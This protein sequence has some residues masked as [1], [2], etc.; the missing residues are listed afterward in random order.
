MHSMPH[1]NTKLINL[2]VSYLTPCGTV[3]K[4][5]CLLLRSEALLPLKK[6]DLSF[7]TRDSAPLRVVVPANPC[8]KYGNHASWPEPSVWPGPG[9]SA[10]AEDQRLGT[11]ILLPRNT[12]PGTQRGVTI[13]RAAETG[14]LTMF[15]L[16]EVTW[17]SLPHLQENLIQ[18]KH[19]GQGRMVIKIIYI[20]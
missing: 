4:T 11:G 10:Q 9:P 15:P 3:C 7:S 20:G 1:S 12:N 16:L 18:V 19:C 13:N 8:P 6:R 2:W 5:G 14:V 17:G